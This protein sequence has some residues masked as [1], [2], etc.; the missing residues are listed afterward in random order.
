MGRICT[1]M[2]G[3]QNYKYTGNKCQRGKNGVEQDHE[4][5]P[6]LDA[7]LIEKTSVLIKGKEVQTK[8]LQRF[9]KVES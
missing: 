4:I 1:I 5:N 6:M 2:G 8:D 9:S 7:Q 3:A